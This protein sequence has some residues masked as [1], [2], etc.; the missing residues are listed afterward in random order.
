MTQ[1]A[2]WWISPPFDRRMWIVNSTCW[3]LIIEEDC[4]FITQN[5]SRNSLVW[6]L[7]GLSLRVSH[8][9]V[10]GRCGTFVSTLSKSECIHCNLE[11]THDS[12]V[13]INHF[14]WPLLG[15][16]LPKVYLTPHSLDSPCAFHALLAIK[17]HLVC[18]ANSHWFDR[19]QIKSL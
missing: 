2:F 3:N 14:Q 1:I 9:K 19:D 10:V 15:W 5:P 8:S 11:G 18:G 12:H 6:N 4:W 13:S 7:A 17:E 16:Y